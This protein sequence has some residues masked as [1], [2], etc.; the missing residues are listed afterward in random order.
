[1]NVWGGARGIGGRS[2]GQGVGGVGR[3]EH[4]F[5]SHTHGDGELLPGLEQSL[6]GGDA[7]GGAIGEV[8][9]HCADFAAGDFIGGDERLHGI[10]HDAAA[11][12]RLLINIPRAAGGDGGPIRHGGVDE[13]I[14]NG[15]VEIEQA[16]L[17]FHATGGL[18]S[19]HDIPPA[20]AQ[21]RHVDLVTEVALIEAELRE[22][23]IGGAA[24]G[25]QGARGDSV[26][27]LL[28]HG[29]I[30]LG[31]IGGGGTRIV[32]SS[33][34]LGERSVGVAGGSLRRDYAIELGLGAQ[35]GSPAVLNLLLLGVEQRVVAQG[36]FEGAR[37]GERGIPIRFIGRSRRRGGL[38]V[39][40]QSECEQH[41]QDS[42]RHILLFSLRCYKI[43]N[44][45]DF[46]PGAQ[47][48]C[49]R[50]ARLRTVQRSRGCVCRVKAFL[51]F[52]GGLAQVRFC[53]FCFFRQRSRVRFCVF[54]FF[55]DVCRVRFREFTLH[56]KF[57][58]PARLKAI[59][60]ALVKAGESAFETTDQLQNPG[61][62]GEASECEGLE[63]EIRLPWMGEPLA[64][65]LVA[66]DRFFESDDSP[67]EP[68]CPNG[69][70]D[71]RVC[72]GAAMAIL[73]F[74][75][76]AEA[77]DGFGDAHRDIRGFDGFRI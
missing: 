51:L 26:V 32:E 58:R 29:G 1:M 31:R 38:R 6:V 16:G 39:R 54:T 69:V 5:R 43:A 2:G 25:E 67:E 33:L 8:G 48:S 70:L 37:E 30:D 35:Q 45:R 10:E 56:S 53:V 64:G 15:L 57:K 46:P 49:D 44:P 9:L 66:H 63:I 50:T 75:T 27:K 59:D 11:G 77:G 40:E 4:V 52:A 62:V 13:E 20:P 3:G 42:C 72:R 41:Q 73:G 36:G 18:L 23:I 65:N 71:Q 7:G 60:G 68:I 74:K 12:F 61:F 19:A 28:R 24:D 22:D 47:M 55:R 34:D 17:D 76:G 21:K 14:G